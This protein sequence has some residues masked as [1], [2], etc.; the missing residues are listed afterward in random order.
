VYFSRFF[1]GTITDRLYLEGLHFLMPRDAIIPYDCR[2]Q[3]KEYSITALTRGAL[4]VNVEMTVVWYVE[5]E[6][7]GPLHVQAGPGYRER[8]IDPAATSTVRS[9]IGNYDQS[10]LYDDNPLQLQEDVLNLMSET[11]KNAQFTI[12]SILIREIQLPAQMKSAISEKFVAEQNVLAERY[13]VLEALESYKRSYVNAESIRL[14]QSIVNQGMSEA[15]LRYLGINATLEL[16]KSDNAKL[17]IIGDKDGMPLILNTGTLDTSA[18]LPQGLRA[19]DYIPPGQEGARMQTMM[20]TFDKMQDY[21]NIM[22]NVLGD[23][24]DR[25]P[26]A[27]DGIGSVALP[28]TN[29]VPSIQR[30]ED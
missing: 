9:V 21:L 18:T 19:E 13:R 8:V 1:G 30:E 22:D 27:N 25:F 10:R 14:A 3:S 7:T 23:M 17:V 12:H 26:R 4:N 6:Q 24:V 16:A 2:L 29:Q 5:P 28:Q 20:N 15:Y 11:L